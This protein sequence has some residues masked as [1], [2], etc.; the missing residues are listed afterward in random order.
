MRDVEFHSTDL[1]RAADFLSQRYSKVSMSSESADPAVHMRRRCLG[2]I[3]FDELQF[4]SEI[5]YDIAPLD[6][7][8]LTRVRDGYYVVDR[9]DGASQTLT[10]KNEYAVILTGDS[11][12]GRLQGRYETITFDNSELA[13]VAAT[14]AADPEAVQLTSSDPV[15]AA[16]A[17]QLTTYIDYLREHV[18]DQPEARD[19]PVIARNAVSML[20]ACVLNTFRNSV[21]TRTER[22]LAAQPHLVRSAVAFIEEYA[23]TGLSLGDIAASVHVTPRALQ[24]MFRRHLD[25]TPISYVRRVR[26][27]RAHDELIS[28]N[29][30]RASVATIA[31]RWGFAHG[32]RFAAYYR[33]RYGQDPHVTLWNRTGGR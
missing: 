1:D 5:R 27:Q 8:V 18:L 7:V 25:C 23:H 19:S 32:G 26:L 24:H 12:V 11:H 20:A 3:S 22:Q 33:E 6:R 2:S 30:D 28:A 31:A 17:T 21:S 9:A 15:S 4:D 29:P 16:A 14:G 13:K 10:P